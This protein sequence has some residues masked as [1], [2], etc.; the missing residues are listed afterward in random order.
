MTDDLIS[1]IR[2]DLATKGYPLEMRA[3]RAFERAGWRAELGRLY[4]D[5]DS[6]KQRDIDVVAS[7]TVAHD[8]DSRATVEFVV[9]CKQSREKPWVGFASE[10]SEH[11]FY[12]F[13]SVV[14]GE[15]SARSLDSLIVQD[16]EAIGGFLKPAGIVWHGVSAAFVNPGDNSPTA[17]FAAIRGA[18]SAA[19]ALAYEA[20]EQLDRLVGELFSWPTITI[21][22]VVVDGPLAQYSISASGEESVELVSDGWVQTHHHN[23]AFSLAVHVV[24]HEHL[25]QYLLGVTPQVQQLAALVA[26]EAKKVVHVYKGMRRLRTAAP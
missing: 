25:E 6:R 23:S 8:R 9:E 3:A 21:P 20:E 17:P 1:R 22:L 15:L 11:R 19:A 5:H 13:D 4:T 7:I 16:Q 24:W 12:M 26:Q 2:K 10:V 14:V 18:V